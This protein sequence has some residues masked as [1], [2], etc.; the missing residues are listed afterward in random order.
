LEAAAKEWEGTPFCERSAVKGA[1]VS[2]HMLAF[3][4][5]RD[6]GWLPDMDIP[7][8]PVGWSRAQNHS[9]MEEWLDRGEGRNWFERVAALDAIEP[10]DLLGFRLGH[11]IHHLAVLLSGGRVVSS[12]ENLGARISP[13]LQPVWMK[14]MAGA[15]RPRL[16]GRDVEIFIAGNPS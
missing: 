16:I 2:C 10:G 3:V 11:C 1:G 15:W 5:Y 4:V 9:V 12:V 13:C 8:A 14:R 7:M 6:A